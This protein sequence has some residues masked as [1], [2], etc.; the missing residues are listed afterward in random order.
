M[1]SQRVRQDWATFTFTFKLRIQTD[2]CWTIGANNSQNRPALEKSQT[3]VFSSVKWE[4]S[5][6]PSQ[7]S[8]AEAKCDNYQLPGS[9]TFKHVLAYSC[10]TALSVP[11]GAQSEAAVCT[12]VPPSGLPSGPGR[13]RAQKRAAPGAS[14][15]VWSMHTRGV[16]VSVLTSQFLWPTPSPLVSTHVFS[17][18]VSLFLLC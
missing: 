17:T 5:L 13:C 10:L 6:F 15:G 8:G 11:T 2:L 12:R 1:G 4:L 3:Q 16:R 7:R 9:G 18:S 14:H